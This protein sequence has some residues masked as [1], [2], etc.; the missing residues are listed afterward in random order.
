MTTLYNSDRR[1]VLFSAR[2]PGAIK[3]GT[4]AGASILANIA[5]NQIY[6]ACG[7]T[8]AT[9]FYFCDV[10]ISGTGAGYAGWS[11]ATR[12]IRIPV[13]P[14]AQYCEFYFY[15][16]RDE[17]V[18]EA[19]PYI[20]I[21]A[22]AS[23]DVRRISV[24][25]VGADP[26]GKT[27]MTDSAFGSWVAAKGIVTG[28]VPS[29]PGA[30]SLVATPNEYWQGFD[31]TIAVS[32]RVYVHGAAYRVLPGRTRYAFPSGASGGPVGGP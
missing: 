29:D 3:N 19:T 26:A 24:F 10:A 9:N 23:T 17:T 2:P 21:T 30:L 22:V 1:P 7:E 18:G 32:P 8:A 28:G 20:D 4:M 15:A 25:P 5:D 13:P 31:V 14:F 27:G 6:L 11:N 16:W 12:Q